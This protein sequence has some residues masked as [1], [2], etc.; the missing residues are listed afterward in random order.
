MGF[1]VENASAKIIILPSLWYSPSTVIV[2]LTAQL[3]QGPQLSEKKRYVNMSTLVEFTG[4][5]LFPTLLNHIV[6]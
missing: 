1:L 4:F 6:R 2:L 3:D 5:P